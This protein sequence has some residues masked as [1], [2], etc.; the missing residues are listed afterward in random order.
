MWTSCAMVQPIVTTSLMR[1]QFFA[2]SVKC[3][4]IPLRIAHLRIAPWWAM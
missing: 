4:T 1:I 3:A 2:M